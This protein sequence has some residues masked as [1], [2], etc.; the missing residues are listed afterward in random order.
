MLKRS[1]PGLLSIGRKTAPGKLAAF[2][3][4]AD[5]FTTDTF[6]SAGIITAIA[7]GEVFFFTALHETL[8][9]KTQF[10]QSTG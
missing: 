9:S 5:A 10:K 1:I 8:L 4:V 2:E 7:G 6:A 3:V